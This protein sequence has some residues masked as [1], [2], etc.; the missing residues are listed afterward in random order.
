MRFLREAVLWF[1]VVAIVIY[2]YLVAAGAALFGARGFHRETNQ[3]S[4]FILKSQQT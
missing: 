3:R 1:F 4:S 2:F